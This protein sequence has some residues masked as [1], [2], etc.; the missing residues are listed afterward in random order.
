MKSKLLLLFR[1]MLHRAD[2]VIVAEGEAT[3]ATAIATAYVAV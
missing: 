2:T 3:A 1:T